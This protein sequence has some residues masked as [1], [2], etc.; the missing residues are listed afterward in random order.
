M[1]N[2]FLEKQKIL[3]KFPVGSKVKYKYK[4]RSAGT[5]LGV[6][7]YWSMDGKWRWMIET[8][9]DDLVRSFWNPDV[10]ELDLEV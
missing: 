1:K 7:W 5:V 4:G 9:E 8:D 3:K 2:I 6:K 10:L